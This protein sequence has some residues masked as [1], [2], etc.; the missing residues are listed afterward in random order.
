MRR[1][2]TAAG[3]RLHI[4]GDHPR[5]L[6]DAV[7]SKRQREHDEWRDP[8]APLRSSYPY[9]LRSEEI[10][11]GSA[12]NFAVDDVFPILA[13]AALR[14]AKIRKRRCIDQPEPA[15]SLRA[16]F[17]ARAAYAHCH[18]IAFGVLLVTIGLVEFPQK[19]EGMNFEIF[20]H[21][22]VNREHG[23][24]L[25]MGVSHYTLRCR[26]PSL[27]FAARARPAMTAA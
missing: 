7:T 17:G 11:D 19:Y 24:S 10:L 23:A 21:Q 5:P 15:A 27:Y 2:K 12:R 25:Y 4:A 6:S 20:I 26:S 1:G 18:V 22:R 13:R 9:A 16:A 3:H 8:W 14:N